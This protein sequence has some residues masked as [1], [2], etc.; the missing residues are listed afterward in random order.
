MNRASCGGD[1]LL[2]SLGGSPFSKLTETTSLFGK[3]FLFL[4][5]LTSLL[6][7]WRGSECHMT[8]LEK[9]T[10]TYFCT[11]NKPL[12][13]LFISRGLLKIVRTPERKHSFAQSTLEMK[14]LW[15]CI[16]ITP[17]CIMLS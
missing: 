12:H 17:S 9:S 6:L 15:R 10:L 1:S 11:A 13:S 7:L 14:V 16:K 3:Y 4:P 2:W 5:L 8:L